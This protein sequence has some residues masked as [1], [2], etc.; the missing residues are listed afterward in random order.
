MRGPAHPLP[1]RPA[2]A[3]DIGPDIRYEFSSSLSEV[4]ILRKPQPAPDS[5]GATG[6]EKWAELEPRLTERNSITLDQLLIYCRA[7]ETW[8]AA[9]ENIDRPQEVLHVKTDRGT[10]TRTTAAS[11]Q[12]AADME[13]SM[14][15]AAEYLVQRMR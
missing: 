4:R 3:G 7:Y 15:Q 5:L 13:R 14:Q 12:V 9:Q 11:R 6:A 10:V 8:R 1:S 2:P